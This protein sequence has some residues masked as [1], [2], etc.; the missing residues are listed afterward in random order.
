MRRVARRKN[1]VKVGRQ[2]GEQIIQRRIH[3]A[4]CREV[5]VVNHQ[6]RGFGEQ[7]VERVEERIGGNP[8]RADFL[9]EGEWRIAE[10]GETQSKSRYEVREKL[11]RVAIAF[12]DRVPKDARV[13][14]GDAQAGER[15]R[16]AIAR[17]RLDDGDALIERLAQ[18]S[19][20]AR[21]G[22]RVA[23]QSRRI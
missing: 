18:Q 23:R 9:K 17:T 6:E 5:V 3:L 8:R 4:G 15:G 1:D 20:Y 7:V 10:R 16:F 19:I 22:E 2:I 14:V 13:R 11:L 12:A 21:T